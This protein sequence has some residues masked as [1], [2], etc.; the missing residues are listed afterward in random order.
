MEENKVQKT[1]NPEAPAW[2]PKEWRSTLNPE[3]PSWEPMGWGSKVDKEAS[4]LSTVK[5]AIE[6][7]GIN[8]EA[9]WK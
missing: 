1:L 6:E 7:D 9:F 3:A 5:T 2:L 8:Q 4:A